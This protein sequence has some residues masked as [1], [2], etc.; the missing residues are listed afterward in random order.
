MYLHTTLL[1]CSTALVHAAP[2]IIPRGIMNVD[3]GLARM[4]SNDQVRAI[5][6][7]AP[8][9]CWD[10]TIPWPQNDLPFPVQDGQG[11]NQLSLY[12]I[13]PTT[14]NTLTI[15]NYCDYDIYYLHLGGPTTLGTGVL[16][17][18]EQFSAPLAGGTN[19]KGSKS[20]DHSSPVQ[21]EY[22]TDS[23][24]ITWYNLSLIDCLVKKDGINTRDASRCAGHELGLQ[25]GNKEVISYQCKPGTWCD[26][27]L[28]LYQIGLTME[29]CAANKK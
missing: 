4:T 12:T 27:Q 1:L 29:F 23:T 26:D 21:I 19:W 15:H 11:G 17:A 2:R 24:G 5:M 20:P 18:H 14:P 8:A 28:Y 3:T 10:G 25:F 16:R 9:R 7:A 6:D 13:P 22:S